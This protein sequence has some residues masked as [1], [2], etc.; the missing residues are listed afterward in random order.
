MIDTRSDYQS[1]AEVR[2]ALVEK[3]RCEILPPHPNLAYSPKPMT[4]FVREIGGVR[5]HVDL[6][7]NDDDIVTWDTA[8]YIQRRLRMMLGTLKF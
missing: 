3:Y 5:V 4:T 1:F 2:K 8:A 7:M 6:F